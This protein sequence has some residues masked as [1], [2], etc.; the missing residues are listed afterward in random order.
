MLSTRLYYYLL[1]RHQI[2]ICTYCDRVNIYCSKNCSVPAI[3]KYLRRSSQRSDIL[4]VRMSDFIKSVSVVVC[5]HAGQGAL[6]I[7]FDQGV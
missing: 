5:I 7:S 3:Q 2:E 6:A 1:C 4:E